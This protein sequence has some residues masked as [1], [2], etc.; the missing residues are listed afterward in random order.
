MMGRH[1]Q[2]IYRLFIQDI[3]HSNPRF[4]NSPYTLCAHCQQVYSL[5]FSNV[6][7]TS[8]STVVYAKHVTVSA[9]P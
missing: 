6:K 1:W 4:H 7:R 2:P 5:E 3:Q 8:S 9:P